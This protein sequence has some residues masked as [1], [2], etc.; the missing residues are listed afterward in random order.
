MNRILL[1]ALF[2]SLSYTEEISIFN[3]GNLNLKN[4]YG[5]TESEEHIIKNKEALKKLDNK[6][7][8]LQ[9]KFKSIDEQFSGFKTVIES[10]TVKIHQIE[11]KNFKI[12]KNLEKANESN[13]V[14]NKTIETL[15]EDIK[16]LKLNLTD[17]QVN[18]NKDIDN[19]K[20]VVAELTS[21]LKEI[22]S[23]Y[24]SRNEVENMM[25]QFITI[26][27]FNKLTL[28]LN[29]QLNNQLRKI[30]PKN[31]FSTEKSNLE[32]LRDAKRFYKNKEYQD[33]SIR[34]EYLIKKNYKPARANFYLGE[35]SYYSKSYSN[36]VFYYKKSITLYDKASYL[37]T[38]LLHSAISFDRLSDSDNASLFYHTLLDS[39]PNSKE[40]K[41][42]KKFL[43]KYEN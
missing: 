36:A 19:F 7:L 24:I 43:S 39:F 3:A 21:F 6:A 23:A 11:L 8:T 26:K 22:N 35:I 40:I 33:A 20:K 37:P 25:S 16:N 32:I 13:Q 9:K 12:I 4:P 41:L 15:Q 42:A 38:L 2:T 28:N 18:Y 1:I 31:V 34:F 30:K 10:N 14:Q 17:F 5:L 27:D 29:N